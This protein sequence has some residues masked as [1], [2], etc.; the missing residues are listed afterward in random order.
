LARL[1]EAWPGVP[2]PM[3]QAIVTMAQA[4]ARKNGES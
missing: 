1:I 3:R 4:A 2:E